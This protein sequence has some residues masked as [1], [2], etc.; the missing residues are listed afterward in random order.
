MA[1]E[2]VERPIDR[3]RVQDVR[4]DLEMVAKLEEVP[5]EATAR[6]EISAP[7]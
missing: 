6:F 7:R 4:K 5:L 1:F 3:Q 2:Q